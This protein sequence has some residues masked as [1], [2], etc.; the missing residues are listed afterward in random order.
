VALI[1]A[2]GVQVVSLSAIVDGPHGAIAAGLVVCCSRAALPVACRRR[3]SA[4]RKD[5]LGLAVAG[6]VP[7]VAAAAV[8]LAATAALIG[9]GALLG[10]WWLGLVAGTVSLGAVMILIAVARDRLGGVTGDVLGAA[11]EISFSIMIGSLAA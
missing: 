4:A 8:W 7:A 5:G 10:Q 6:S 1:L 2:L 11:V 3:I 9:A